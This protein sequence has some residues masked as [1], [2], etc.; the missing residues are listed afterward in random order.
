MLH[1][2]DFLQKSSLVATAL[3]IDPTFITFFNAKASKVAIQQYT[4]FSYL[5]REGIVWDADLKEFL[6]QLKDNGFHGFEPSFGNPEEADNLH[7]LFPDYNIWAS[8]MYVNSTLHEKDK[9]EESINSAVAIAKAARKLGVKIVVTNPS[10]IKWG[11]PEDKTDAQLVLQAKA[12]DKL[13]SELRKMGLKLA[14]HTHDME[15]RKSAR[16]FHH[17]MLNTASENVHLCL[18]SHW[19]YRGAGNSQEALFDIIKLYGSRITE[20]HLRQSTDHIWSEVFGDGDIDYDRMVGMIADK[21][22]KPHL[23]LEQAV[24][25]GTS[26]TMSALD[27][28]RKGMDYTEELCKSLI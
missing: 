8:S 9:I 3:T 24:E 6:G 2:R 11:D 7:A 10:P 19:V 4:W 25:E 13:G 12:L 26:Q 27:A 21:N 1:R 16:E 22:L 5:R 23:V 18:D 14:Y 17:M 28:L 15:M 20:L